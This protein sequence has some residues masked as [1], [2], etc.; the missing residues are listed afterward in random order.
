MIFMTFFTVQSLLIW[1]AIVVWK[2]WYRNGCRVRKWR[3]PIK[4]S[5]GCGWVYGG[6]MVGDLRDFDGF[7]GVLWGFDGFCGVL[8]GFAGFCGVLRDFD[9]FCGVLM[10]FL[11]FVGF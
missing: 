4:G 10:G 1:A 3:L 11:R 7:C 2:L 9:G 6:F 5:R 8:K